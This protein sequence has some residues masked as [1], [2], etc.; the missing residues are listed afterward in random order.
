MGMTFIIS[1]TVWREVKHLF[2]DE[3]GNFIA[4]VTVTTSPFDPYQIHA[5]DTVKDVLKDI[6]DENKIPYKIRDY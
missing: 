1:Q 4:G 5:D 3:K 2:F 6:L